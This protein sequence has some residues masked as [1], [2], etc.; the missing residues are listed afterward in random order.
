MKKPSLCSLRRATA[1]SVVL[2]AG[3]LAVQ[4]IQVRAGDPGRISWSRDELQVV[5]SRCG[6]A[7]AKELRDYFQSAP[8]ARQKIAFSAESHA[9]LAKHPAVVRKMAW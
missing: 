3:Q 2:F 8:D 6:K 4:E 5:Q 9:L 1:L 7:L